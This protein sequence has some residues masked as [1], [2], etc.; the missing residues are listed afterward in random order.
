MQ[1]QQG[2]NFPR[3]VKT[4]NSVHKKSGARENMM[5]CARKR[6]DD[7]CSEFIALNVENHVLIR[8]NRVI[9]MFF[10]MNIL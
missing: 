9:Q 4:Q 1:W 6:Q 7:N 3:D 8:E 10:I 5:A 2:E